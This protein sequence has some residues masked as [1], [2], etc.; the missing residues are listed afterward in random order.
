MIEIHLPEELER[1]IDGEVESGRFSTRDQVVSEALE[2]FRRANAHAPESMTLM[3]LFSDEPDL[4][5]D[6]IE[7]AMKDRE[8]RPLRVPTDG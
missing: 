6:V 4:M 2:R 1:Y 3:G 5:D 7:S 8:S